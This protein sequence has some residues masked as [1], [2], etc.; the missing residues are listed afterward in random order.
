MPGRKETLARFAALGGITRML[1]SLPRRPFLLSFN[2]HRIGDASVTPFDPGTYSCTTADFEAQLQHFQRFFNI[3]T[4]EEALA[5][6]E[7]RPLRRSSILLTF[8]DGYL[9]NYTE[10]YPLLQRHSVPATFFLP[11]AFTGTGRI[12]WWD[13][14]AWIVKQSRR[15]AITLTYPDRRTFDLTRPDRSLPAIL[16]QFK[17]PSM[18]D[19]KRFIDDLERLCGTSRPPAEA[20]RCFLSWDEA[21]E[22]QA[23]GMDFGS[24]GHTHEILSKLTLAAQIDELRLSREILERELGRTV[25]TL[26]YPVGQRHTFSPDTHTALATTGYRTAFSFF[27]GINKPGS[28]SPY[29]VFRTGIDSAP[30]DVLRLRTSLQ[31]TFGVNWL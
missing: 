11:T 9:D 2:Y 22:M 16:K 7:G 30:A 5:V 21:R 15:H 14:I 23:H 13:V 19:S 24:H 28:I 29:N 25:D 4:L 26:A 31:T 3:L 17:K 27:S 8:D 1:E 6:I 12:P 18:Q 20:N 10:A